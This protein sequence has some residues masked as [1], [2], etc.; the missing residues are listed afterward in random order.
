[1]RQSPGLFGSTSSPRVGLADR[2]A[3]DRD[4]QDDRQ[5]DEH[6]ADG[7]REEL[8]ADR[9]HLGEAGFERRARRRSGMRRPRPAPRRRGTAPCRP[10]LAAVCLLRLVRWWSYQPQF[11]Q[12]RRDPV[13]LVL[14]ELLELPHRSRTRRS[15][16]SSP[17]PPSTAGCRASPRA[18]ST[19]ACLAS[20]EMPGGARTPRQLANVRSIPAS[21]SVGAS[22]PSTRS[23]LDTA[24]TRSW[25]ASIWSMSSPGLDVP[26]VI[27]L[28]SSA[29]SRSPPPS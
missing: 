28:P 8:R 7:D 18:P 13:V 6:D 26:T 9:I 24:S 17:A 11:G 29:V 14:Q 2:A 4:G 20:S 1:M 12:G 27:F 19:I 3:R 22:M 16:R 10:V 25:P 15:S 21:F 23:S 5:H